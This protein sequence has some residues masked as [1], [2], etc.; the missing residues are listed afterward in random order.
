MEKRTSLTDMGDFSARSDYNR[1]EDLKAFDETNAGVKGLADAGLVDI[2][3]IFMRPPEELAQELK[4]SQTNIQAPIIDLSDIQ[5]CNR[6]KEI[7]EEVRL[8]SEKWGFFQVVNHGI[9][10]SVFDNM[11]DGVRLFNEQDL[12]EKKKFYSRDIAKKVRFNSNYDLYKSRFANWRDTLTMP[13][14]DDHLDHEQLPA[15]CRYML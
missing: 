4:S 5:K 11:I 12:E 3:K 13:A 15:A 10:S 1:M 6:H 9:P 2:P 14:S 7:V 8:A